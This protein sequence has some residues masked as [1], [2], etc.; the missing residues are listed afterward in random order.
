MIP[1]KQST[2]SQ[3]RMM[4]SMVDSTDFTT[5]ESGLTINN[6]DVK[7]CKNGAASVNKN[8]GGATHR[9]NGAYSL[10]FDA[11]DTDTVGELYVSINV[12][13]AL[14]SEEKFWVYEE[15]IYD[16]N[17]GSGA[18]GLLPAN[19]TQINGDT[20]SATRLALSAKQI[21]P[22]TVDTTAVSS[23]TTSFESDDITE[24]TDNHYNGRIVIFTSGNLSGQATDITSYTNNGGNGAFTVTALTEAPTD[25]DT[26]IIV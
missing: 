7:L 9:I 19:V 10:T 18:A 23:T 1:L 5:L 17:F 12:S 8:S 14:V 26:F 3:S 25:N 11:T 2:A 13:G 22:G 21:I 4:Y 16:A 20:D 24:A 15:A 6:T